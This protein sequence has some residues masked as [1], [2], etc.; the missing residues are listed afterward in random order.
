MFYRENLIELESFMAQEGDAFCLDVTVPHA[1]DL[2]SDVPKE[3][4]AICMSTNEYDF[5]QVCNMLCDTG[6]IH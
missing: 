1:V 3:R 6:Y 2:L 5:E 4:V